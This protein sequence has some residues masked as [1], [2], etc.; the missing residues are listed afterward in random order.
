MWPFHQH[1]WIEQSRH[2]TG[3]AGLSSVA[4]GDSETIERLVWG[5]TV[6]VLRCQACGDLKAVGIKGN[7]CGSGG[8]SPQSVGAVA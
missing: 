1:H 6:V 4:R 7:A 8:I 3:P 2:F 5:Y